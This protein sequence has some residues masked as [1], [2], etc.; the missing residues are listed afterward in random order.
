MHGGINS[1]EVEKNLKG[2]DGNQPHCS[3]AEGRGL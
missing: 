2:S 1:V 3:T